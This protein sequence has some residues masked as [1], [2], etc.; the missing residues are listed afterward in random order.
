MFSA[1]E[2]H[3]KASS[4]CWHLTVVQHTLGGTAGAVGVQGG[5]CAPGH[6]EAIEMEA[7]IWIGVAAMIV[8]AAVIAAIG[9]PGG[10]PGGKRRSRTVRST[11]GHNSGLV[12]SMWSSD[13]GSSSCGDSSGGGF[14]G[15]DGGGGG[16][17]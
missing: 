7:V 16:S 2:P 15:G 10:G 3:L 6:E 4:R 8:I 17:C 14:G 5:R 1:A 9:R 12:A 13:T 11:A